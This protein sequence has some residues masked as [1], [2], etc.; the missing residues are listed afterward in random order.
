MGYKY[1]CSLT[2]QDCAAL[3]HSRNSTSGPSKLPFTNKSC[4]RDARLEG[5]VGRCGFPGAPCVLQGN[6]MDNCAGGGDSAAYFGYKQICV[7]D[8]AGS[9]TTGFCR[10]EAG[11]V[12]TGNAECKWGMSC[13]HTYNQGIFFA[14]VCGG[15]NAYMNNNEAADGLDFGRDYCL[16][17]K[18]HQ[19]PTTNYW[20]CSEGPPMML[21]VAPSPLPSPSPSPSPDSG[22][23][24]KMSEVGVIVGPIAA[25]LAITVLAGVYFLR[26]RHSQRE[27]KSA[28][29]EGGPPIR[30]RDIHIGEK[31][32]ESTHEHVRSAGG[33]GGPHTQDGADRL[34]VSWKSVVGQRRKDRGHEDVHQMDGRGDGETEEEWLERMVRESNERMAKL[35]AMKR[36]LDE[37]RKMEARMD[38]SDA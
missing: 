1:Q 38:G 18:A 23:S 32:R 2:A 20:L 5:N 21:T 6:G 27:S 14:G 22:P 10:G 3:Y 36:R 11:A 15:A 35:D 29:L 37:R 24:K 12:C 16:S 30:K 19:D 33:E 28:S 25:V 26:R 17:G 8:A 13:N 34:A 9:S 31:P 4:V 7:A